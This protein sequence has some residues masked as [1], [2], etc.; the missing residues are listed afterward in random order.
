MGDSINSEETGAI[1][2]LGLSRWA[3][4]CPHLST[5]GVSGSSWCWWSSLR[6]MSVFPFCLECFPGCP[7]PRSQQSIFRAV[8]SFCPEHI[9][10]SKHKHGA[11]SLLQPFIFIVYLPDISIPPTLWPQCLELRIHDLVGWINKWVSEWRKE[12]FLQGRRKN[13]TAI[14]HKQIPFAL[15]HGRD[16]LA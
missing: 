10:S 1:V 8:F 6:N 2:V 7:L 9:L 16:V 15:N 12:G 5:C 14:A 13:I 3:F 11:P 4:L